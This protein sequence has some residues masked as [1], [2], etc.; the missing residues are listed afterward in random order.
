MSDTFI[1]IE[2]V[3][4]DPDAAS[5]FIQ[6]VF[7]G[8]PVEPRMAAH[9][10][11]VMPGMRCVHVLLGNCVLQFVKPNPAMESWQR[12]LDTQGPGVHNVTFAVDDF[13]AVV[14]ALSARGAETLLA[15][16]DVDLRPA[17]LSYDG[18][19]PV[20]IIDARAQSGLRFELFSSKA[21]W[22]PGETP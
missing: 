14:K 16:D 11:S 8:V 19:L 20:H 17:G 22:I 12:Q 18:A 6:E 7:G 13:D 9:L 15:V 4:P 2:I 21:G 5:R 3:H 1:H 10:E